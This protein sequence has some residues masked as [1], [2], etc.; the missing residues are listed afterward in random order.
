MSPDQDAL[1]RLRAL[2]PPPALPI[3][4]VGPQVWS[5]VERELGLKLPTDFKQLLEEYGLGAFN[6]FL[7][8]FNPAVANPHMNLLHSAAEYARIDRSS[9]ADGV[10]IP[11]PIHPEQGGLLAWGKTDNGDVLFWLTDPPEDPDSWPIVAS[12]SRGPNWYRHP[13][14]ASSFLA[15]L[16]SG[17]IQVPFI[18]PDQIGGEPRF[19]SF[20]A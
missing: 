15:D 12:E 8:A 5:D 14:P 18:G 10:P 13:G 4:A 9:R 11:Y 16:L 2:G 17:A 1:A 20:A 7:F 19:E 3:S 6:D